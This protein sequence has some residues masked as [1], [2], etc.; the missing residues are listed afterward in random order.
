MLLSAV[1]VL[2][3]AQS[4]S[5]IPEGLMN[6]LYIPGRF[7]KNSQTSNCFMRMDGQAATTKLRVAFR[8]FAKVPI[9]QSAHKLCVDWIQL[10]LDRTQRPALVNM[11]MGNALTG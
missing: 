7:W 3:V 6:N 8:S 5:E 4:N 11:I 10:V 2:V 9:K 1:S